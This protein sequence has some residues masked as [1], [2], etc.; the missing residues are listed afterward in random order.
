MKNIWIIGSNS[1]IGSNVSKFILKKKNFENLLCF[2][3][4]KSVFYNQRFKGF[5]K[6]IRFKEFSLLQLDSLA[7]KSFYPDIILYFIG[8][9]TVSSTNRDIIYY[10]NG[11]ISILNLILEWILCSKKNIKL[12]YTSSAAVNSVNNHKNHTYPVSLYGM[13]KLIGEEICKFYFRNYGIKSS[14]IRPYSIFGIGLKKQLIWDL[15]LKFSYQKQT[16]IFLDGNGNEKREFLHIDDLC[17]QIY[18][19]LKNK[20]LNKTF[21]LG[22]GNPISIKKISILFKKLWKK[23]TGLSINIKFK[24]NITK[25][26]NLISKDSFKILKKNSYEKKLEKDIS[27]VID[28]YLKV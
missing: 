15:C 10:S 7:K 24:N 26:K 2:G 18:A 20:N 13:H 25:P 22:T 3:K 14:I 8:S 17:K 19:I 5:K 23:K 21:E 6:N 4:S 11:N 9:P 28:W 1:Y 16:S 27:K 12:I